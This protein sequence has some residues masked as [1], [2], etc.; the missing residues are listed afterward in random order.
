MHIVKKLL[1]A[2]VFL[3][4]LAITFYL[5]NPYLSSFDKLFTFG[6]ESFVELA[7][8]TLFLTLACLS[9]ILFAALSFDWRYVFPISVAGGLVPFLIIPSSVGVILGAGI[10]VALIITNLVLENRLKAY[11]DFHPS[12]L[13]TPSV[14]QL[15]SLI[16]LALAFSF[17]LSTTSSISQKGFEIPDSLINSSLNLM[18]QNSFSNTED[19]LS[20]SSDLT[21]TLLKK[22]IKEQFKTMLDPYLGIIP[23]V[24]AAL[25]FVS[26][27]SIASL[28]FIL[29][30]SLIFIIFYLLE[31]SNFIRF[32][33]EMREVK[34]LVI[35]SLPNSSPP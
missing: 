8:L 16:I 32:E 13:L 17:Y 20:N 15:S 10:F 3:I 30:P 27:H 9:S 11:I 24:L 12:A 2:P 21:Q 33:K 22:T 28:L 4:L 26:L 19:N 35:S 6:L 7:I 23:L 29:F 14:K 31:K 1:I 34:K 18:P 25:F 5:F